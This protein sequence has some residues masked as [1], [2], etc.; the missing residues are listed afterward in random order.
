M[1]APLAVCLHSLHMEH[2]VRSAEAIRDWPR[3]DERLEQAVRH[4]RDAMYLCTV[5]KITQAEESL[6][7]S[8]LSFAMPAPDARF[9][10]S[11]T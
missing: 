8:I 1:S 3:C 6:L 10:E 5:G 9:D 7:F 11:V 4:I 2:L